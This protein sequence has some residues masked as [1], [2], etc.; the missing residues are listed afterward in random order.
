M[1]PVSNRFIFFFARFIWEK[2]KNDANFWKIGVIKD[3]NNFTK[4]M[5]RAEIGWSGRCAT[6]E[7][8]SGREIKE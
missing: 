2:F 3:A 1:R 6:Y 8:E 5:F 7:W 4:L